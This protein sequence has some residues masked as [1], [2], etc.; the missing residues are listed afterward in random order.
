MIMKRRLKYFVIAVV[1]VL[2]MYN[3]YEYST[4]AKLCKQIASGQ[5]IDIRHSNGTTMPLWLNRIAAILQFEGPKIPLVE[6]CYYRNV[7][8][9]KRLLDNG[10]DPNFFIP[11]RM[12]ALEAA[13]WNGPAGPI[14]EKS[15]EI[16]KILVDAGYDIDLYAS[17]KP[18]ILTLAESM[19]HSRSSIREDILLYLLTCK[20]MSGAFEYP[21]ILFHMIRGGHTHMVTELVKE[22]GFD[23]NYQDKNG[24]TPLILA[25]SYS[26]KSATVDMIRQLLELGADPTL[27]DRYGKSA[28]EYATKNNNGEILDILE[29]YD[30]QSR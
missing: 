3:L 23:I 20:G 6:A 29:N 22:Y 18:V 28:T 14:D 9:V 27:E 24:V 7:Q 12:T 5:P 11:D 17:S 8:A 13:L 1:I 15:L 30:R 2:C 26:D 21:E 16:T 4:T 10:A 25:V 19:I